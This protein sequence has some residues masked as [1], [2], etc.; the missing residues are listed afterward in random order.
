VESVLA[1]VRQTFRAVAVTVVPEAASLEPADWA[2]LESTVERALARRPAALRRQLRTFLRLIGVLPVA[3]FGRTF[4]S[5]DEA[6]R[7]RVLDGLQDSRVFL[8]RKGFWGLRTLVLM[9]YY[10][11]PRTRSAI[12][13]R[14]SPM[15]WEA[16]R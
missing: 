5:L 11:L 6:R 16:R 4:A 15:G 14:A 10:T 8:L 2:R 13:Y 1:P 9:G 7:T 3:R 12:G